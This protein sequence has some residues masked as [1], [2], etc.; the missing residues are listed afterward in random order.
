ME[1]V[2]IDVKG[3]KIYAESDQHELYDIF[4]PNKEYR[5]SSTEA[6]SYIS[7][8]HKVIAVKRDT[9]SF[10]VAYKDLE[11]INQN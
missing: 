3:Y 6:Q 2:E 11:E 4:I 7:D 10:K 8:H 1:Y 9:R 5:M